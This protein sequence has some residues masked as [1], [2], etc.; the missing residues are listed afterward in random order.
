MIQARN[1]VLFFSPTGAFDLNFKYQVICLCHIKYLVSCLKVLPASTPAWSHHPPGSVL[2][3]FQG[4]FAASTLSLGSAPTIIINP[5]LA[6]AHIF[7]V[8]P[9]IGWMQSRLSGSYQINYTWVSSIW[10]IPPETSRMCPH[11]VSLF[12]TYPIVSFVKIWE[13]SIENCILLVKAPQSFRFCF[14]TSNSYYYF[15]QEHLLIPCITN[16]FPWY[17]LL[18]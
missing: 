9:S 1:H 6:S 3:D 5:F 14:C 17:S 2:A 16:N 15:Q 13:L 4:Y 8:S 18:W 7:P 12:S 11:L 10:M